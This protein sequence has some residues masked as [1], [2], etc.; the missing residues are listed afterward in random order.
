MSSESFSDSQESFLTKA[1]L[2]EQTL[3]SYI[4]LFWFLLLETHIKRKNLT[5]RGNLQW[6]WWICH[7]AFSFEQ[8]VYIKHFCKRLPGKRTLIRFCASLCSASDWMWLV[9]ATYV[10]TGKSQTGLGVV[11]FY[12]MQLYKDSKHISEILTKDPWNWLLTMC[13]DEHCELR[14]SDASIDAFRGGENIFLRTSQ[15]LHLRPAH[16]NVGGDWTMDSVLLLNSVERKFTRGSDTCVL[17]QT[18][19][20]AVKHL[21]QTPRFWFCCPWFW[22]VFPEVTLHPLDS[23][24]TLCFLLVGSDQHQHQPAPC[25]FS[26]WSHFHKKTASRHPNASADAYMNVQM[27]SPKSAGSC[28]R[29]LAQRGRSRHRLMRGN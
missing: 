28:L 6:T 16:R 18:L 17:L 29:F 9:V 20:K 13:R 1:P 22:V 2:R 10:S 3:T 5:N 4:G 8:N 24:F 27:P 25:L 23:L 15:M 7:I 14:L 26:A 12:W 21:F 19:G 11:S